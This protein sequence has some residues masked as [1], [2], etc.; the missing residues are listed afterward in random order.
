MRHKAQAF[1]SARQVSGGKQNLGSKKEHTLFVYTMYLPT[2]AG[3]YGW[4]GDVK[5]IDWG[6]NVLSPIW[7]P[8]WCHQNLMISRGGTTEVAVVFTP[9]INTEGH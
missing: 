5:G 8:K 4:G 7:H 3:G 2:T 6:G 1:Q 9:Q